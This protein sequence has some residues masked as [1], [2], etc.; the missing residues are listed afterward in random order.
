M[1][2]FRILGVYFPYHKAQN[3]LTSC[4]VARFVA[5]LS[6]AFDFCIVACAFDSCLQ[7][8]M[9]HMAHNLGTG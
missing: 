2:D 9:I 6:K 7:K 4:I 5:A 8:V 3:I 1:F